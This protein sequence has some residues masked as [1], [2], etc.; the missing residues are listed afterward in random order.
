MIYLGES[1]PML[2][3]FGVLK[4]I[5]TLMSIIHKKSKFSKYKMAAARNVNN[6]W[7]KTD[8]RVPIEPFLTS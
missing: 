1:R 4:R 8:K 7:N 2:M 3:K 5:G 6:G